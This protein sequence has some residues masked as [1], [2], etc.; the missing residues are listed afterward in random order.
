MLLAEYEGGSLF[1]LWFMA[2]VFVIAVCSLREGR[3]RDDGRGRGPYGMLIWEEQ[4][5]ARITAQARARELLRSHLDEAQRTEFDRSRSFIVVAPS[6]HRY[7]I[8]AAN[9]FNVQDETEHSDYCMQFRSDPDCRGVPLEDLMLAQKLLLECD[10]REF[11]RIANKRAVPARG[12]DGR[13]GPRCGGV[14]SRS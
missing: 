4:R 9:T 1:V 6:G 12:G 3:Y 10:E 2:V 13:F 14:I 5:E 8:T 11:I 7:R